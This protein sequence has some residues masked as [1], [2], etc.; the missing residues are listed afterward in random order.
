M[1]KQLVGKYFQELG[2]LIGITNPIS[3][4]NPKTLQ[5]FMMVFPG[6]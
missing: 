5:K 3:N 6:K 2:L 4:L 1:L